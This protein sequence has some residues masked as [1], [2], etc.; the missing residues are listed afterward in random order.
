M[1][2]VY[3]LK[4]LINKDIYIGYSEDLRNRFKLHNMG[5]V[6]SSK[7]YR[8]WVLVYYEAYRVKNDATRREAELK[9][10]AAKNKLREQIK[11]SLDT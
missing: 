3:V 9:I 11:Y 8:P 2:Y 10:H 1:F 7:P 6:A 4:S 5:R